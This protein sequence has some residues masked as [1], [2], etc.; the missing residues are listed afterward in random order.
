M[1]IIQKYVVVAATITLSMVAAPA[2]AAIFLDFEDLGGSFTFVPTSYQG[3]TWS[4]AFGSN[5]WVVG[6]ES[7]NT[8]SGTEAHSQNHYT[9]SNGG[10]DLSISGGPF[11]FN[12]LWARDASPSG[13]AIA[14]GFLGSTELFTQTLTM[15]DSYQLFTL[16]FIGIDSWTLTDQTSNTLIDDI[17]LNDSVAAVP[18]ASSM[19]VWS[20]LALTIAG[21]CWW[22]RTKLVA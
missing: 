2:P 15:T 1:N 9:W 19:I 3:F 12:S 4:G 16:N 10:G 18:E 8:F 22:K 7:D 21:A 13:T 17:T 5:S 14:H 11:T 6:L 20:F